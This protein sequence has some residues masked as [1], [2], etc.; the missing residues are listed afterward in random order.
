MPPT[1]KDATSPHPNRVYDQLYDLRRG[2]SGDHERP[3]K[4]ALLLAL[5]DL[6]DSGHFAENNFSLDY[7]GGGRRVSAKV[8][9]STISRS[10]FGP[11]PGFILSFPQ[12][13]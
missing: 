2:K 9:S 6:I 12:S 11:K 7:F 8:K 13:S 1:Q 5:V 10:F 3:H 4:P